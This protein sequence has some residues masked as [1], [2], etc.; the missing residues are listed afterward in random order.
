MYKRLYGWSVFVLSWAL[1]ALCQGGEFFVQH[2]SD[3]SQDSPQYYRVHCKPDSKESGE[4]SG[5]ESIKS[6]DK[7]YWYC[8]ELVLQFNTEGTN[9]HN[10]P[11]LCFTN[12][13]TIKYTNHKPFAEHTQSDLDSE[14][15][16]VCCYS[17]EALT[18]ASKSIKTETESK[19]W[20]LRLTAAARKMP[21]LHFDGTKAY[22]SGTFQRLTCLVY[23]LELASSSQK[24]VGQLV[25]TFTDLSLSDVETDLSLSDFGQ[26]QKPYHRIF[27]D[28]FC[29]TPDENV[30]F[31]NKSE[32]FIEKLEDGKLTPCTTIP[33]E[34]FRKAD[35][36]LNVEQWHQFFNETEAHND[37]D[38]PTNSTNGANPDS[39][40]DFLARDTEDTCLQR[41]DSL[42]STSAMV[43]LS[44]EPVDC[45]S[46]DSDSR[47]SAF[48]CNG[49]SGANN[50]IPP[51]LVEKVNEAIKCIK[52][53]IN[54]RDAQRGANGHQPIDVPK[55]LGS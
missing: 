53:Q 14:D 50:A 45:I 18:N 7:M 37:C 41:G 49:G 25:E 10:S 15:Q 55:T 28:I 31:P 27:H 47:Q 11:S 3:P 23:P 21:M 42:N 13:P 51:E 8:I 36:L 43:N 6:D 32:L 12:S 39:N 34:L 38:T 19:R 52:A 26:D 30:D 54:A 48:S 35:G 29:L 40:P 44:C 2:M 5:E 20:F 46:G 17:W 22:A 1:T 16:P 9:E 4:A 33:E 24:R